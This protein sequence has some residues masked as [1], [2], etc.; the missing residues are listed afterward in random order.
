MRRLAP[1]RRALLVFGVL[2]IL[3]AV[4]GWRVR[5]RIALEMHLVARYTDAEARLLHGMDP[6]SI[7]DIARVLRETT[8]DDRRHA[9]A[10]ALSACRKTAAFDAL[11]EASRSSPPN[12]L[13]DSALELNAMESDPDLLRAWTHDLSLEDALRRI[14]TSPDSVVRGTL[15]HAFASGRPEW[16]VP[17]S[18][19]LLAHDS[20]FLL[21]NDVLNVLCPDLNGSFPMP[22]FLGRYVPPPSESEVVD[23]LTAGLD[24]PEAIIRDDCKRA[25]MRFT[26]QGLTDDELCYLIIGEADRPLVLRVLWYL[27]RRRSPKLDEARSD[28]LHLSKDPELV[29]AILDGIEAGRS[30]E[31]VGRIVEDGL[32][33]RDQV[34]HDLCE[35]WLRARGIPYRDRQKELPR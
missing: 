4:L 10:T 35:A 21:A 1:F 27:E 9:A 2:L 18:K 11:L 15:F 31:E 16:T 32:W 24:N 19:E 14:R 17:M 29:R 22:R 3:L 28:Q 8:D 12:S 26:D 33:N 30:E 25:L 7:E 23:S 5:R 34:V 20:D 13:S 6:Q